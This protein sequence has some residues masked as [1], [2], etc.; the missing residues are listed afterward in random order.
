MWESSHRATSPFVTVTPVDFYAD[1]SFRKWWWRDSFFCLLPPRV[2][3][4]I[5]M[6]HSVAYLITNETAFALEIRFKQ[7]STIQ[8]TVYTR[9]SKPERSMFSWLSR[10]IYRKKKNLFSS[11][12]FRFETHNVKTYFI[13]KTKP[14]SD[15]ASIGIYYTFT[16]RVW[17]SCDLYGGSNEHI[18]HGRSVKT[19]HLH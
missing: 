18:F 19:F 17:N 1:V 15:S 11:T 3:L 16:R 12:G 5:S 7:Q 14:F 4:C 10:G 2:K 13:L 8:C 6:R 9:K